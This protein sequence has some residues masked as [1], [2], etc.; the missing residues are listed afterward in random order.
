MKKQLVTILSVGVLIFFIVIMFLF[1]VDGEERIKI[2][3]RSGLDGFRDAT[4][5]FCIN[6]TSQIEDARFFFKYDL[7][8]KH[9]MSVI[10]IHRDKNK[11]IGVIISVLKRNMLKLSKR[12]KKVKITA[13]TCPGVLAGINIRSHNKICLVRSYH[14]I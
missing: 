8:R 5:M 13:T 9:T 14:N 2:K 7:P 1:F 11:F 10:A 12:V 4:W 3:D 6:K